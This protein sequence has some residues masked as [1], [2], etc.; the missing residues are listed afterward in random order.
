MEG[1]VRSASLLASIEERFAF[2][3]A[4]GF[5][6]EQSTEKPPCAWYRNGDRTIVVAYDPVEDAAISV[7]LRFGRETYGLWDLFSLTSEGARREGVRERTLIEAELKRA[8]SLV[9]TDCEDFLH[10]DLEAF[11]LNR[12]E[13]LL[14]AR[15]RAMAREEFWNGDQRRSLDLFEIFRAYWDAND[16]TCHAHLVSGE[17]RSGHLRAAKAR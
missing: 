15:L 1:Q 4:R 11:R 3:E 7:R 10:G 2:L 9:E 14:V 5:H 8:A 13:P 12:R 17:G 16:R 6:L